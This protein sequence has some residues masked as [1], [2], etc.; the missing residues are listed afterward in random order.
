MVTLD[1]IDKFA[2]F[3]PADVGEKITRTVQLLEGA[4]VWPEQLSSGLA[5]SEAFGPVKVTMP[6]TRF[7]VPVF[8]IVNTC[9]AC[10]L[11]TMTLPKS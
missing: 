11:P 9:E 2:L 6:I 1:G 3:A 4:M 5:N 10:T 7:A 8:V